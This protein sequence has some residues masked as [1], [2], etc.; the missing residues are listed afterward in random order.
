LFCF[1]VQKISKIS[2]FCTRKTKQNKTKQNVEKEEEECLFY[3][4]PLLKHL[5]RCSVCDPTK[6]YFSH[7][8]LVICFFSNLTHKTKIR[9][10]N[11]WETTDSKPPGPIIM[12]A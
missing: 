7:P 9:N 10:A 4:K 5:Q 11:T 8:S 3:S 2:R 1:A 6:N 12:V